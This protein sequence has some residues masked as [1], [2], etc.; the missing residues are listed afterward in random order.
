MKR[1]FLISILLFAILL[2]FILSAH[3]TLVDRG[4]GLI[5]DTVLKVT[6]LQDANYANTKDYVKSDGNGRM[7]WANAKEWADN[8]VYQ[9]YSDWRLPNALDAHGRPCTGDDCLSTEMLHLF[10][11]EGIDTS[12]PAPFINLQFQYWSL[13]ESPYNS[14]D[15]AISYNVSGGHSHTDKSSYIHAWAVRDGDSSVPSDD[16]N[17]DEDE[18]EKEELLLDPFFEE[19]CFIA[20]AAFGS[21]DN[22]YVKILRDFRDRFLLTNSPGQ[23]FVRFYYKHSP[24]AAAFISKHENLKAITRFALMPAVEMSYLALKLF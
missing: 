10:I 8:L 7:Q 3:A 5:Y 12:S 9:G 23:S 1:L 14:A 21:Y 13:T 4:G 11:N 15:L 22:Y 6:F 19:H 2:V 16:D 17:N 20:T 24:A 18:E